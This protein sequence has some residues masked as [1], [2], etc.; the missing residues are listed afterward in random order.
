MDEILIKELKRTIGGDVVEDKETIAAFSH[1]A[2]LFEVKPQVVVYPKDIKDIETLVAF[3]GK[4]K[5]KYPSLS[6]TARSAGTDMGG[7]SINDS[8]IVAFGKY[9]N[10]TPKVYED[11][12]ITE[13]GVFY[14]DFEK[15]TLKHNLIFPSYPASR[16][17]C[18]MGGIVNNNS[19]GEK[20]LHYGKTENYVRRIKVVLS[21]GNTYDLK[22]LSEKELKEKMKLKTFE[23]NIYKKMYT[24]ITENYDDIMKA[25]PS[26][27]K[28][29]AGYAL[30]N[31][32]DKG[33]KLFDLT[34][35]FVGAQGTL[36]MLLEAEI[37]L[38]SI[39]MH[40][41]M[42]VIFLHDLSHLGQIIDAVLPLKPE[43][44]ESYDDNTLMLALRFFPEF[45]KQLGLKGLIQAGIAFLP[46]FIQMFLGK[47]PKLILQVDFASNN[48]NELKE[49]IAILLEKLKPLHP[50]VTIALDDQEKKYWLVRRES[51]N[52]LRHKIR[53]K[54]TAPFIDDFV[55]DPQK[56]AEVVP[57]VTD[58][59]K[60]HPEFIFTVAG[61]VGDGNFH[62]IPLVDIALPSV[63][64]AIP[65]I[66]QQVYEI[67]VKYK[68]ST[69]GEHNDGLIRTPYL[70]LMYGERMVHLFEET[71]KI[72]DPENIFN[73]RKK[74]DGNL[75]YAMSHIRENW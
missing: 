11:F 47:L 40:R 12:A 2:S 54:H 14:R 31:V 19:G 35:L 32:L 25:A 8:I 7:G 38:V 61:H 55:I 45:A 33:K 44:F 68:G 24:L 10:H 67:I 37:G 41:E 34:K 62:I 66:A 4:H 58:I 71:K 65:E 30:W 21:D 23:G 5:K 48:K 72:F 52:L 15:E 27:S 29:S 64:T 26:V 73:P 70:K 53:N 74:V 75:D 59:L 63:R 20:S 50:K 42:A 56:I 57:Q 9:F 16:E 3:V 1:D 18:A 22:P 6:L 69:T 51:F 36:G 49:K 46:A 39:K 17:I 60:K 28:N 43:S 13:P